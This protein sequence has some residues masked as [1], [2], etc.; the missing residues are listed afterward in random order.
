LKTVVV[1]RAGNLSVAGHLGEMRAWLAEH[2]IV[3]RELSV[4]HVIGF[5]VVFRAIF[6]SSAEADRFAARFDRLPVPT[7]V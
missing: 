1:S 3:P 7:L 6:E 4:L 2:N 5:R